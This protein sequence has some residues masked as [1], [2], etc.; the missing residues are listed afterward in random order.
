M[1]LFRWDQ[2]DGTDWLA[3]AGELGDDLHTIVSDGTELLTFGKSDDDAILYATTA[4]TS[5]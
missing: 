2:A 1:G 3:G 4:D 5:R